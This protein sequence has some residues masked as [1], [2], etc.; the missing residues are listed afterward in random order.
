MKSIPADIEM[1]YDPDSDF[2]IFV[3]KNIPADCIF[4]VEIY[5]CKKKMPINGMSKFNKLKSKLLSIFN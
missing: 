2:G 3:E 1:Y 5:D 4:D